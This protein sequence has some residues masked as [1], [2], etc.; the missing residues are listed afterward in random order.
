[1]F[2]TTCVHYENVTGNKKFRAYLRGIANVIIRQTWILLQLNLLETF[3]TN[4]KT[5]IPSWSSFTPVLGCIV[6][7]GACLL[8]CIICFPIII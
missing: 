7:I 6:A 2:V 3:W 8:L 4:L 5:A 1:M